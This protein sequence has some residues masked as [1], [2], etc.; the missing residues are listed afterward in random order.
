MWCYRVHG[1][2]EC[3]VYIATQNRKRE[4]QNHRETNEPATQKHKITSFTLAKTR[5]VKK[6][7]LQVALDLNALSFSASR[8]HI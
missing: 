6:M 8:L 3:A 2:Q 5:P 1:E 7:I 4:Q